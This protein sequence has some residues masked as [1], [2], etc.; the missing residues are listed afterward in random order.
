MNK[1]K[2]RQIGDRQFRKQDLNDKIVIMGYLGEKED[3]FYLD[4][5]KTK[6]VNGVEIHAAIVEEILDL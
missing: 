4:H 6:K 2:E 3:F 1:E 5:R